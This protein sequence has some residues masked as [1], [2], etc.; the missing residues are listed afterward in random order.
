MWFVNQ[1]IICGVRRFVNRAVEGPEKDE[2][3]GDRG[4]CII[5]SF[6]ICTPR[7]IFRSKMKRDIA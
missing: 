1:F 3:T 5:T 2:V 4:E 6:M 7:Q